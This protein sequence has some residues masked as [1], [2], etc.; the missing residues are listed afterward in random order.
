MFPRAGQPAPDFESRSDDGRMVRLRDLRGRWVVLS[1]YPRAASP[2]CS[3]QAQGLEAALP[4]FARL[5]AQ[6]VGVSGDTEARQASFRERCGLSFPL[7]PDGTRRIS[8]AYGV[9][10]GLGAWLGLSARVTFLIDP[11]GTVAHIHRGADPATHAAAA[12]DE[13]RRRGAGRS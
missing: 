9:P 4:E 13:L 7:L 2:G 6:V 12:L 1:F 10:G 5:G 8:R 3:V 11:H